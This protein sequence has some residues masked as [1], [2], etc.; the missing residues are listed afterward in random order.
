MVGRRLVACSDLNEWWIPDVAE[1]TCNEIV[2][3]VTA[4]ADAA[5]AVEK[6]VANAANAI[7]VAAESALEAAKNAYTEVTRWFEQLGEDIQCVRAPSN[8]RGSPR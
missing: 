2:N 5:L 1:N 3:G 4:I 8:P 6:E 7:K